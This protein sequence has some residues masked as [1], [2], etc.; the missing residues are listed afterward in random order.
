MVSIMFRTHKSLS[1]SGKISSL[2]VFD[3]LARSARDAID[4]KKVVTDP[5]SSTGNC[6]TFLLKLEGV[7]ESFIQ[8]LVGTKS[9][10][11]K[12]SI[13]FLPLGSSDRFCARIRP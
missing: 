2:Y 3:A 9:S 4:K 8:D 12:V 1:P 11:V 7:L 5:S 6:S 13:S 10:E